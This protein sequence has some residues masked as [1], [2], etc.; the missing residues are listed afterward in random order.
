M[1]AFFRRRVEAT[2]EHMIGMLDEMDGDTDREPEPTEE[3]H[4]RE[5]VPLG[6]SPDFV[7]AAV[8]RRYR[9]TRH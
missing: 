6:A 1:S 2:I 5:A 3:Q 8:G 9:K 7:L 4:D